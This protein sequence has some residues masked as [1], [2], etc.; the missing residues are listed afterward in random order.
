MCVIIINIMVL[1]GYIRVMT[2]VGL[3]KTR[4]RKRVLVVF[5]HLFDYWYG[6]RASLKTGFNATVL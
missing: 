1:L 4:E 6:L 5:I 2:A 3:S